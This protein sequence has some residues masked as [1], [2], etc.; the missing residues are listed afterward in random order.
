V[1]PSR[2]CAPLPAPEQR[3]WHQRISSHTPAQGHTWLTRAR[4][5]RAHCRRAESQAL[6]DSVCRARKLTSRLCFGTPAPL[7]V[8]ATR[9]G[10][11]SQPVRRAD[12]R[13]TSRLQ[14]TAVAERPRIGLRQMR[15]KLRARVDR[16]ECRHCEACLCQYE[17][18]SRCVLYA[19]YAWR[20]RPAANSAGAHVGARFY[21]MP[22][23]TVGCQ[24]AG[25]GSGRRLIGSLSTRGRSRDECYFT[26]VMKCF[27][28]G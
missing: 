14:R 11:R 28:V 25:G 9:V 12:G 22:M 7:V 13:S 16:A 6:R 24:C 3:G 27:G 1:G 20:A 2:W 18:Q 10:V 4:Q 19:W 15:Y 21:Q 17:Y 23:N 5:L 8:L 26:L